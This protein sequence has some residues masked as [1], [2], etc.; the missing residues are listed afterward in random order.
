MKDELLAS[1]YQENLIPSI[2]PISPKKLGCELHA[3]I[4]K[5]SV[6]LLQLKTIRSK[7]R[8]FD[9]HELPTSLNIESIER[10]YHN[11]PCSY[12]N[13]EA[14]KIMIRLTKKQVKE[15]AEWSFHLSLTKAKVFN[16]FLVNKPSL[17]A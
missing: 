5:V 14:R 10:K 12:Y 17:H 7:D 13:L 8:I 9:F 2:A 4:C 3:K 16:Y 6:I 11:V 15:D 1:L